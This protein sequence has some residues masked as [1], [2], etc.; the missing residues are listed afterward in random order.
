[1]LISHMEGGLSFESFGG[2]IDVNEDT[3][4]QW[5]HDHL[6]FSEAYKRGRLKS[7]LHWEEM[8]HDMVLAGQGNAT[9]WIFNMKNRFGWK[10]KQEI[11]QNN[12]GEI[13]IN[14]KDYGPG[15]NTTTKTEGSTGTK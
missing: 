5:K 3:L 4:Y 11:E 13:N 15:H 1:M 9:T 2:R 8:G 6:E 7:M 14:I 12:K 10:D